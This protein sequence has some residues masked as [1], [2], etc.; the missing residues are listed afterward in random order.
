MMMINSQ[1]LLDNLLMNIKKI[2]AF[3]LVA[4]LRCGVA[5]FGQPAIPQADL[6]LLR[7]GQLHVFLCGTGS[8]L[9]DAQR[10]SACVAVIAGGEFLLIDAGPGSWR[11]AA[12]GNL[13]A[14]SL[15]AILIT[16]FH[17][18][19][20]GDLGAHRWASL[21]AARSA[22]QAVTAFWYADSS[23]LRKRSENAFQLSAS[24][25]EST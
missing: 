4:W 23:P 25:A 16:H 18:D 19:H 21:A 12:I 24:R 3:A 20:I 15:S 5:A 9:P 10:A 13:P 7:D 17:S 22:R 2:V 1:N 11:Q 6:S 14:Q 8:P